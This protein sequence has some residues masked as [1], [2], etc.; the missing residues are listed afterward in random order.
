MILIVGGSCQGK[1]EF[2]RKLAETDVAGQGADGM[3][4]SWKQAEGRRYLLNYHGFVRQ[5]MEDGVDSDMVTERIC[6]DGLQIVTLDEVGCGI[7]PMERNERDYREAV[8]RAGQILTARAD[9]VYRM[10]CGIPARIK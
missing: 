9:T 8:G 2:A 5:M 3:S 4:D 1:A 10:V 7:V 6:G